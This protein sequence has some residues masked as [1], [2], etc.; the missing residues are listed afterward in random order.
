M[1]RSSKYKETF[2]A[3]LTMNP[4]SHTLLQR[5]MPQTR[6][7]FADEYTGC[8]KN[9]I[10]VFDGEQ[11]RSKEQQEQY[12]R[13]RKPESRRVRMSDWESKT[14]RRVTRSSCDAEELASKEC[15][16]IIRNWEAR[17]TW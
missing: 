2:C 12:R 4:L 13:A 10:S 3:T 17:L 15:V 9:I 1:L 7:D 8:T 6:D 16:E 14:Q 11:A 5:T